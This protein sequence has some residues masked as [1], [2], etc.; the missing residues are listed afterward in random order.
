MEQGSEEGIGLDRTK[1]GRTGPYPAP[2]CV[3]TAE[4]LSC[5]LGCC[6]RTDVVNKGAA[7]KRLQSDWRTSM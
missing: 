2:G 3:C 5:G 1:R 7:L 6:F 4:P